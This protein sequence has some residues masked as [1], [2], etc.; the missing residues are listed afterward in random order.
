[1]AICQA[2]Q[3]LVAV[4]VTTTLPSCSDQFGCLFGPQMA[5]PRYD[6]RLFIASGVV[7]DMAMYPYCVR[8]RHPKLSAFPAKVRK[9]RRLNPAIDARLNRWPVE[10]GFPSTRHRDPCQPGHLVVQLRPKPRGG[11]IA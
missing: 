2:Q 8:G 5:T 6:F 3:Q 7:L 10:A 9:S 11:S 4:R 1:M